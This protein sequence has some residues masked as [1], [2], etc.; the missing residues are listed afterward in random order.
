MSTALSPWRGDCSE[1]ERAL[2]YQHSWS[3]ADEALIIA[4]Q[5]LQGS[6]SSN[7]LG[8]CR[9]FPEKPDAACETPA[10][11]PSPARCELLDRRLPLVG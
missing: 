5:L 1:S 4:P 10:I 2:A 6:R 11:V 7:S 3:A 8:M 9:G